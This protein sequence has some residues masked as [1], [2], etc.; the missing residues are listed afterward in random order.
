MGTT[1]SAS[2][3]LNADL[4]VYSLALGSAQVLSNG[5]YHFNSGL[6]DPQNVYAI[7]DEVLPDGTLDYGLQIDRAV[8]RSFRMPDMYTPPSGTN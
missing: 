2:L 4:G 3:V 8:Y 6:I 1:L 5:N 7:G